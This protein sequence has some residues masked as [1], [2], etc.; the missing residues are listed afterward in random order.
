MLVYRVL[1][2]NYRGCLYHNEIDAYL[3][4]ALC[5]IP[6]GTSRN[7]QNTFCYKKGRGERY[8]YHF[9]VFAEDAFKYLLTKNHPEEY[10]IGEFEIQD[11]LIPLYSGFGTGYRFTMIPNSVFKNCKCKKIKFQ[12]IVK[13]SLELAVPKSEMQKSYMIFPT[14]AEYLEM[15]EEKREHFFDEHYFRLFCLYPTTRIYEFGDKKIEECFREVYEEYESHLYPEFLSAYH[16]SYYDQCDE[17][18][19]Y[20]YSLKKEDILSRKRI[21]EKYHL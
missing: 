3:T 8:Y 14:K 12:E 19:K 18:I 2:S 13:P 17:F 9:F 1:S 4:G 10:Q 15:T 7:N 5:S 16:V 21:L 11:D 6:S 20:P